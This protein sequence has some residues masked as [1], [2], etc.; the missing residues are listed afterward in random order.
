MQIVK[1]A[2]EH[3][4][5]LVEKL[6]VRMLP[7]IIT[8]QGGVAGE[9][10]VGFDRLG[11]RDDFETAVLEKLLVDWCVVIKPASADAPGGG[12]VSM[13]IRKSLYRGLNKTASDEDSDFSD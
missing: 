12:A 10:I 8:F 9:R 6:Q 13:T 7:C 4:P 5:F 1:V 2:A 3:A 11:R